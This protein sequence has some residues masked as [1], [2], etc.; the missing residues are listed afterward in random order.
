[1]WKVKKL[2]EINK[3]VEECGHLAKYGCLLSTESTVNRLFSHS[4]LF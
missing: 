4:F 3:K 1:M 2:Q